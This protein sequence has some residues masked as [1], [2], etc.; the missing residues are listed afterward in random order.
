MTQALRQS[1]RGLWPSRIIPWNGFLEEV[2]QFSFDQREQKF[3]RPQ[4]VEGIRAHVEYN[5][6]TAMD[7]NIFRT[8]NSLLSP[9]FEF[10]KQKDSD[11]NFDD[12]NIGLGK[13]DF[14]CQ[15]YDSSNDHTGK[16]I[17]EI[18]RDCVMTQLREI[19]LSELFDEHF[20]GHARGDLVNVISQVYNYM[21]VDKL[22]YG[23]IATYN[24]HWF[25][26]RPN[27]DLS[28]LL[29]SESLLLQSTSPPVFKTYVYLVRLVTSKPKS[30]HLNVISG[31]TRQ[32]IRV[33]GFRIQN[34]GF[35]NQSFSQ[36]LGPDRSY[37]VKRNSSNK[38]NGD[39]LAKRKFALIGLFT[40]F[41]QLS[42]ISG[43]ISKHVKDHYVECLLCEFAQW[44]RY[45]EWKVEGQLD[46][47]KW[48][49]KFKEADNAVISTKMVSSKI[50]SYESLDLEI[51]YRLNA[52]DRES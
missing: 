1:S 51:Y 45:Y 42:T 4:F 24:Y 21:I 10:L 30:P 15:K 47:S 2:T 32:D 22:Q 13:S 3:S 52:I 43:I 9:T 25:F 29:I 7:F 8:L 46:Y 11:F 31:R 6:K 12:S 35:Y 37:F 49:L 38:I 41:Y 36:S 50:I 19:S 20:T 26:H 27:A 14:T 23:I 39:V 44:A 18:K 16:R 40:A 17:I 5:V 48:I 34:L 33:Q 28:I